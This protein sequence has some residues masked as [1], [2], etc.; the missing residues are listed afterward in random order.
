MLFTSNYQ[1]RG[2]DT[3]E[4][5]GENLEKEVQSHWSWVNL[6][7]KLVRYMDLLSH[8]I[9]LCAHVTCITEILSIG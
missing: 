3:S 7:Y 6:I 9:C 2:E 4:D 1:E 8:R 5:Q